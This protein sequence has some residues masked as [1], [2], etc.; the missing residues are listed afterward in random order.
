MFL[1]KISKFLINFQFHTFS[2]SR[3]VT[4]TNDAPVQARIEPE[5]AAA[6]TPTSQR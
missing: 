3:R 6:A 2:A 5:V 4:S 1:I